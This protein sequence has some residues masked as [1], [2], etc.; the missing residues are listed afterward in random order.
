MMLIMSI[1]F[2]FIA[3]ILS[4]FGKGGGE[5]YLPILLSFGLPYQKAATMTLF[6]LMTSGIT[7][8][9]VFRKKAL[10]D[11]TTGIFIILF[12]A[13]GAFLG[14]LVSADINPA[15]LKLTFAVLLLI[16]AYFISKPP[17]KEG[18]FQLGWMW[19]RTCCG[20]TY[21]IPV[22]LVFPLIFLIGFVAGMVGISGGG[23]VVPVLLLIGNVP[24]R[25]A[26]ATNSLLVLFSSALGFSGH[27]IRTSIDWTST[28]ILA[29][30]IVLGAIIGANLSSKINLKHLKKI[31]VY[32]LII[33]A[34]FMIF[35]IFH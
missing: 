7:M 35:K 20:E 4:M 3:I 14:G 11:M 15:Y 33:A 6:I 24:L 25:I 31:F 27:I 12:S 19:K 23:L 17:K 18:L 28:L 8:T 1:T 9:I 21:S 5:F 16:S 32:V 29:G 13:S 34:I 10:I 22:F 26:F 30:I 2:F